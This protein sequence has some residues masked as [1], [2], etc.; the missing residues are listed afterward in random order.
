MRCRLSIE[1]LHARLGDAHQT[2]VFGGRKLHEEVVDRV[3]AHAVVADFVMEV[4]RQR[5]AR[6]ARKGDDVAA[7]HLLALA[8]VDLREVVVRRSMT[9]V[10]PDVELRWA[11]SRTVPSAVAKTR[12][13][14]GMV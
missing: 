9:T 13:P 4:G 5:K 10:C 3:H 12:D 11:T 6:V 14:S 8:D 7:A 2:L 1:R